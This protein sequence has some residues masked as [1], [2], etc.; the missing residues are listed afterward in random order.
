MF[1]IEASHLFCSAKHD[2]FLYET[3]NCM[4][5]VNMLFISQNFQQNYVD[6]I[7]GKVIPTNLCELNYGEINSIIWGN[8]SFSLCLKKQNRKTKT[9]GK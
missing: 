5:W 7:M 8:V 3:Q 2:W 9:N 4:K 1:H 6:L